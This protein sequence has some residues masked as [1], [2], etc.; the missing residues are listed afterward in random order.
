LS[1]QGRR[2]TVGRSQDSR[3][4][5]LGLQNNTFATLLLPTQ[6]N[7]AKDLF[8]DFGHKPDTETTAPVADGKG[9]PVVRNSSAA[10]RFSF[11]AAVPFAAAGAAADNIKLT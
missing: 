7:V 3:V 10:S 9:V 6:K 2:T 8:C 11:V 1:K 5:G 4:A